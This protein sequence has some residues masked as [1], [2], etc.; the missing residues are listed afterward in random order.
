MSHILLGSF[1]LYELFVYFFLYSFLGWC[2]EVIFATLKTG[3]FIN[4]GFL[5]GPVCPIYGT[6]VA[7]LLLCLTP[8]KKYPWAVFFVSVLLCS[9]LEFLTGFVLE[10]IFHKKWWDYSNRK[11]NIGGFICPEMSLL[12][13]IAAIAVLYG[14]QPTF[15]ALLGHIPL[16]AGYIFLG[17]CAAAFVTDLVFTLLQ[18]S[19]LGKRLK[20]LQKI[21]AAL[22]LGS[23]ALGSAL[24]HATAKSAEKIGE[25]RQNGS[26][27]LDNLKESGAQAIENLRYRNAKRTDALYDKIEKSRLAKAFPSLIPSEKR[28]EKVRNTI[29]EWQEKQ[30]GNEK[31]NNTDQPDAAEQTNPQDEHGSDPSEKR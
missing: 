30:S 3:K 15:A 21:N 16:L 27:K 10:K 19:A 9:V 24:S 5:N 4:R 25:I 31:A 6:G 8:L 28:R 20:E 1:S 14:I 26:E 12:W 23:D 17:I 13:G 22:R 2:S 29:Q 18:I 11:F 7:L